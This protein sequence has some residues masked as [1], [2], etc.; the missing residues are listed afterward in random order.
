MDRDC[1]GASWLVCLNKIIRESLATKVTDACLG[2][3]EKGC[4]PHT[5]LKVA[6]SNGWNWA[7]A[8]RLLLPLRAGAGC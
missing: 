8:P 2:P 5:Q 6:V 7:W 1:G 4:E 3:Q